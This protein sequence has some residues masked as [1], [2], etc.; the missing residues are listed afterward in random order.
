MNRLRTRTLA[1]VALLVSLAPASLAAAPVGE[2][3][4]IWITPDEIRSLPRSGNAWDEML[5]DARENLLAIDVSDDRNQS[6]SHMMAAALV[7]R[8]LKEAGDSGAEWYRARVEAACLAARGTELDAEDSLGPSRQVCAVVIAA[9]LIDWSSPAAE[10]PF[11][12]WVDAV[13]NHRFLDDRSITSTH[14][15]RAN[16]WGTHA[17]ASRLACALYLNDVDTAQRCVRVFSGWLGNKKAYDGFN[18]GELSWQADE[19][20]PAGINKAGATKDGRDVDGVLPD[21]Q[22]RA[23][24]FPE[25]W[26]LKSNYPY[27]ALQGVLAQ[28]VMIQ[29][30]YP[31][32][33]EWN[34]RAILRAFRWLDDE[35]DQ[36]ITDPLNGSDDSWQ[37]YLVNRVYGSSFPTPSRTNPGKA[38]GYTDWTTLNAQWP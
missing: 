22:R 17:G 10:A 9:N 38:I 4:W 27:E 6:D 18:W 16:N 30:A 33:W 32:V 2:K 25:D 1:A 19:R 31:T 24:V 13:R 11:R 29:R 23:G 8:R 36:P 3:T 21:D 20:R 5:E 35:Y 37:G 26:S 28:A 7:Y 15:E 14:E 12:A 34:D